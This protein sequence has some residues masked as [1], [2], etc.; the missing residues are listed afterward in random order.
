MVIGWGL[1]EEVLRRFFGRVTVKKVAARFGGW[2]DTTETV[3]GREY[4]PEN[5]QTLFTSL[6]F[7]PI[8]LRKDTTKYRNIT[9]EYLVNSLIY[10]SKDFPAI[11]RILSAPL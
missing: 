3:Y 4:L 2:G 6:I 9:I 7:Y 11:T 8:L 10:S 1:Y 5:I